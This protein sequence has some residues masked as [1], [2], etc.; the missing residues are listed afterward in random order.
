MSVYVL[1]RKL[2][3]K[4]LKDID[5]TGAQAAVYQALDKHTNQPCALK[6][7]DDLQNQAK[8]TAFDTEV[9]S[10]HK[11]RSLPGVIQLYD[12]WRSY[13]HGFLVLELC[14]GS[15]DPMIYGKLNPTEVQEVALFLAQTL[16]SIHKKGI[17]HND[18]KPAN[19]LRLPSKSKKNEMYRICDFGLASKV[20]TEN[21]ILQEFR[22]TVDYVA[23]ECIKAKAGAPGIIGTP[24]VW[25]FGATLYELYTGNVPFYKDSVAETMLSITKTEPDYSFILDVNLLDL[26]KQ[27]FVKDPLLRPSF[28]QLLCQHP[29]LQPRP[30]LQPL[31]PKSPRSEKPI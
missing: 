26:L 18:I 12:T 7:Y 16:N 15:L 23:P 17:Q 19:I 27:V 8:Q 4:V 3:Y 25:S 14:S 2:R 28:Q 10:L 22:G 9:E 6:V 11:L 20:S 24:D 13:R 31:D 1:S 30:P 5:E 29:Y 21:F